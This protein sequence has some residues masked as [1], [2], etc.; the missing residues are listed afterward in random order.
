M[1]RGDTIKG[2]LRLVAGAKF[3]DPRNASLMLHL[4]IVH[5]VGKQNVGEL[6]LNIRAPE[7]QIG[8]AELTESDKPTLA[9]RIDNK[10]SLAARGVSV[11]TPPELR[12][13]DGSA[14][15]EG[16][17]II[18]DTIEPAEARETAEPLVFNLTSEQASTFRKIEKPK[19]TLNLATDF[20][21]VS[22]RLPIRGHFTSGI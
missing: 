17:R 18:V 3:S 15:S 6:T 2:D 1:T 20:S 7:L 4:S 9:V 14:T 5:V 19:I 21:S 13:L 16:S 12:S 11:P 10:G 8:R 22:G